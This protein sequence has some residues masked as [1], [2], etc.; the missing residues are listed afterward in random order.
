MNRAMLSFVAT[1]LMF[2]LVLSSMPQGIVSESCIW[3]IGL[4][5]NTPRDC[6][7]NCSGQG[8]TS[9]HVA[10]NSDTHNC[11]CCSNG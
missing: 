2:S 10:C 6:T 7:D 8:N 4:N 5:C 3:W 9:T 1:V 11:G